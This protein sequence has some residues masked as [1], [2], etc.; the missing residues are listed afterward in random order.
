MN[1][2]NSTQAA[3]P[4]IPQADVAHEP[5]KIRWEKWIFIG[6]AV[7]WL[8]AMTIYPA[9]YSL[10]VSFFNYDLA[11]S[12]QLQGFVGIDNYVTILSDGRFWEA[13]LFTGIYSTI[14]LIA[15]FTLGLMLALVFYKSRLKGIMTAFLVVPMAISPIATGLLWRVL[16][17][18]NSGI[19]NYVLIQIGLEPINWLGNSFWARTSVIIAD[20]WQWTPFMYLVL[21]AGLQSLSEEPIEAARVDGANYM[22]RLFLIILPM[23]RPLIMLALLLRLIDMLKLFDVIFTLTNAGPGTTTETLS[24]LTYQTGFRYFSMGQA[25]AMSW[26]LVIV[27]SIMAMLVLAPLRDVLSGKD[28]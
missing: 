2:F 4:L 28:T 1:S 13:T 21:L 5:N 20:T 23:M 25:A 22:Q 7:I 12:S 10:Y 18:A 17:N 11:T 16:F 26:I 15:Q 8:L 3:Q 6:P 24:F 9:L 27:V 19:V 14:G